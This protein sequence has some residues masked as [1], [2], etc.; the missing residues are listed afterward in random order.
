MKFQWNKLISV[1]Y[2]ENLVNLSDF[3]IDQCGFL[4]LRLYR[5]IFATKKWKK[6]IHDDDGEE[7]DEKKN[8][9]R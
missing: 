7:L 8:R 9:K 2:T 4:D 3:V 6:K 1:F 5:R